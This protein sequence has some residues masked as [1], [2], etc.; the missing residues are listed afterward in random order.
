MKYTDS[1]QKRK[2]E[3]GTKIWACAYAFNNDK[4]TMGLK[5]EPIYGIISRPK[6]SWRAFFVPF[7]KNSS[8]LATSKKVLIDSRDYADSYD[9][10]LE[11]YNERI[12]QKIRW[13]NQRIEE[14]KN[15]LITGE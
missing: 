12:Q 8:G 5:Q 7:K 6:G 2:L 3:D 14:I 11:V 10:C 4:D 15:D 13:F 9:E 1:L